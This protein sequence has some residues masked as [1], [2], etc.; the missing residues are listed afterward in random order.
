MDLAARWASA[1]A[2][3][4]EPPDVVARVGADLLARYAEPHRRYHTAA[5]LRAVLDL[6][7]LDLAVDPGAV[8][9]AAWFHDAIY[10]PRAPRGA[11]EEASAALAAAALASLAAPP[12]II[13]SVPRLVLTTVD[14][15]VGPEDTDGAVLADADLSI[16]GA[17]PEVY[18]AYMAATRD[19]YGWLTAEEWR[20][21]RSAVLEGFL[22]RP[23]LYATE[24]GRAR[25][26][27]AARHNLGA[28]LAS[29]LAQ[30]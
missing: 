23:R 5:H 4:G 17:A 3:W 10:D 1:V 30:A 14:H 29:L 28:E 11:N 22:A 8:A 12:A 19:E 7:F 16:L 27:L 2:P 24:R 9:L 15:V 20:L 25:W 18:R 26:E 6:L 13:H 21:G